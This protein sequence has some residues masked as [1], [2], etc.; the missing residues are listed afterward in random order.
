MAYTSNAN[1]N[2]GPTGSTLS[3]SSNVGFPGG[4]L[5]D[6]SAAFDRA[7]QA[8]REQQAKEDEW[9]RYQAEMERW[10]INA[11]E[12]S[13]MDKKAQRLQVSEMERALQAKDSVAPKRWVQIGPSGYWADDTDQMTARQRELFAPDAAGFA[14]GGVTSGASLSPSAESPSLGSQSASGL[15]SWASQ[16]MATNRQD[17]LGQGMPRTLSAD[18]QLASLMGIISGGGRR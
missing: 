16:Q 5:P 15:P 8:R 10:K 18:E 12:P 6:F 7:D 4:G 1:F 11:A 14:G 2:M 13:D 9:R 17:Q 3:T